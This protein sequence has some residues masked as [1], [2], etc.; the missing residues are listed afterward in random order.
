MKISMLGAFQVE[1]DDNS[2]FTPDPP[3]ERMVLAFF[4]LHSNRIVGIDNIISE[5]WGDDP[6]RTS[7]ATARTY[8]YHLRKIFAER[9][10]PAGDKLL[11]T[12]TNGYL[13]R[14]PEEM[15]DAN[16]FCK[17]VAKGRILLGD[18]RPEEAAITLN[19]A[20]RMW[21]GPALGNVPLGQ[22]LG[23]Y[24]TF[25]EEERRRAQELRIMAD[26]QLGRHRELIS[27]IRSL[28][29]EDPVNEW[30][31]AQLMIALSRCGRRGEALGVY[32][33]LRRQ[34]ATQL[35][36]DPTRDLQQLHHQL[37]VADQQPLIFT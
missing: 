30:L 22:T 36:L 20:L 32:A 23:A 31:S 19:E 33:D 21:R 3:K 8:V 29:V 17:L 1:L 18:E 28:V 5:I 27:E 37:L 14:L 26:M 16:I 34:L 10:G 24:A 9:L 25:L 15:I 35:G 12:K 2:V 4:A 11:M 13:L 6:P 7:V